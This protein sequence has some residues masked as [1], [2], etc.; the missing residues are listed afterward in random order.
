MS[1]VLLRIVPTGALIATRQ[2]T[3]SGQMSYVGTNFVRFVVCVS[4][5]QPACVR[6]DLTMPG[7]AQWALERIDRFR[8]YWTPG[9]LYDVLTE[10]ES[11]TKK[12]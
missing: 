9:Q 5:Q 8:M 11:D 6:Y 1:T 10:F 12:K 2:E 3:S 4:D 7:L